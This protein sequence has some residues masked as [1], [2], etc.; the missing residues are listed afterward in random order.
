MAGFWTQLID[1]IVSMPRTFA[2]V[3][4]NDPLATLMLLVGTVLMALSIGFFSYVS[5][6]AVIA[7]FLP[8][9]SSG[10]SHRP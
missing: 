4:T 6:R 1:S 8:A 7:G 5:V 9:P 10:A 2:P 3:A